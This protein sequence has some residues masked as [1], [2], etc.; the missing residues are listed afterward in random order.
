MG[1]TGILL[2]SLGCPSAQSSI[3]T[4]GLKKET[5]GSPSLGFLQ[6]IE[7]MGCGCK[8]SHPRPCIIP[9]LPFISLP[10]CKGWRMAL[11]SLIL[12]G[13]SN[14]KGLSLPATGQLALLSVLSE[15]IVTALHW[16]FSPGVQV[17]PSILCSSLSQSFL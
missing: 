5:E 3:L 7:H 13:N 2:F 9:I 1:K 11:G 8:R 6:K 4:S 10:R 15:H 12:L 14:V 16:R 17:S